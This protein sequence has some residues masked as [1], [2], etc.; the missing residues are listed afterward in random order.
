MQQGVQA[1]FLDQ[2]NSVREAAVDLIG[3]F[4]MIRPSLTEK[5]YPMIM[6]RILDTGVSVRKRVIKIL[7]YCCGVVYS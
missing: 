2:A 5:Y 7:R 6:E 4:I 3:R 1:R